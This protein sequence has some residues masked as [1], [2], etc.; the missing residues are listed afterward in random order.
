MK[1][2]FNI[3][4][5]FLF[6]WC[7][8]SPRITRRENVHRLHRLT[9][10]NKKLLRG[11]QGGGFLEKN[12]PGRRRHKTLFLFFELQFGEVKI[13]IGDI[14]L[15]LH[16]FTLFIAQELNRAHTAGDKRKSVSQF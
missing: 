11:V 13:M 16:Y 3:H 1:E 10:I 6:Y 7:I 2:D 9:Q 14:D 4:D 5:Y 12:P 15:H 8:D